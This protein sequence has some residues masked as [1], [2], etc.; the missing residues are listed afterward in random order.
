VEE[1]DTAKHTENWTI[2]G[3]GK[4]MRKGSVELRLT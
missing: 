4:R 2:Q 1:Q 3:R